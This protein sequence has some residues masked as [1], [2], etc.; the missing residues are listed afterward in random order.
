MKKLGLIGGIGPESTVKY[1]QQI[2]KSY[3]TRL[4]TEAYPDFLIRSI[5][6]TEMLRYVFQNELDGLTEFLGGHLTELEKSG[7]EVSALASNTPHIV[8][9]RLRGLSGLQLI[10]IVEET[11][12]AID[13]TG[14]KTVALFGTK[15]TMTAGFYQKEA[16]KHSLNII[17]PDEEQMDFIHKVYFEELV[18]KK[19]D[20][21]TKAKLIQICHDMSSKDEIEGLILGGTELSLILEQSDFENLTVFDTTQIHVE[22]IVAE[23]LKT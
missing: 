22:A 13:S 19:I 9:D 16:E 17:L 6:M 18:F 21:N 5:D 8:F 11:C 23:I 20:P 12:K 14:A 3:R 1:Y 15:S 4:S 10:S 7:V 2:I